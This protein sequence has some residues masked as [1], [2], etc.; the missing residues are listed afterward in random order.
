MRK[1]LASEVKTH[2]PR[3]LGDVERGE[4]I[5]ITRH[6]RPIARLVPENA[7]RR[8]ETAKVFAELD[9]LRKTQQIDEDRLL[10]LARAHKL[11]IYDAAYL[12][13]ALCESMTLATLD[14]ALADAARAVQVPLLD[15]EAR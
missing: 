4:T 3:L 5:V 15:G 2:L 7:K 14:T 13:L 11:S 10:A 9:E 6:G 12:E 1:I 8:E